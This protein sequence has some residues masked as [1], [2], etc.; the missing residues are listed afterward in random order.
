MALMRRRVILFEFS[1]NE[2]R[3]HL[4]LN[5]SRQISMGRIVWTLQIRPPETLL[6][7]AIIKQ[8]TQLKRTKINL[9]IALKINYQISR[10]RFQT[11]KQTRKKI[12]LRPMPQSTWWVGWCKVP[13]AHSYMVKI[14][15]EILGPNSSRLL[16]IVR[17]LQLQHLLCLTV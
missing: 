12:L 2:S 15:L 1:R 4:L 8:S 6:E 7:V 16:G 5:A 14:T 17:Q 9:P 10:K 11:S 3:C 13:L